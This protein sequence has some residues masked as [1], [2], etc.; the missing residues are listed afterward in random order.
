MAHFLPLSHPSDWL[1]SVF[2]LWESFN[3]PLYDAGWLDMMAR[4]AEL[5]VDSKKSHPDRI[6]I[7]RQAQGVWPEQVPNLDSLHE[8]IKNSAWNGIRKDVGL[9]TTDQWNSMMSKALQIMQVPV[10][11]VGKVR[12]CCNIPMKH[13]DRFRYVQS[14][15]FLSS[16]TGGITDQQG[17]RA[18]ITETT[19]SIASL[20]V[21]SMSEDVLVPDEVPTSAPASGTS[22]PS[23]ALPTIGRPLAG[24]YA[25]DS[26]AKFVQAT[27]TF[28]HPSNYGQWSL[29]LNKFTQYLATEFY[30]R[31]TV[32]I[33]VALHHNIL[34]LL[35][36]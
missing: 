24:S 4:L 11:R 9:F 20:M 22:T 6:N 8:S 27:E 30:R 14:S 15:G 12:I 25:L 1:T 31:W 7:V 28:F 17:G 23:T 26:L 16:V 3:S 10:G 35:R 5:H 33:S 21:Y 13:T 19:A 2:S 18:A 32:G 29:V 34:I 36:P